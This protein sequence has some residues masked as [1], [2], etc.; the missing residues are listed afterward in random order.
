M[1]TNNTEVE[2]FANIVN[3]DDDAYQDKLK[4]YMLS[5]K[6]ISKAQV[7]E[8]ESRTQAAKVAAAWRAVYIARDEHKVGKSFSKFLEG[9]FGA[10]LGAISRLLTLANAF[11][12]FVRAGNFISEDEYDGSLPV[13]AL[14]VAGRIA[15][16]CRVE[17]GKS[18]GEFDIESPHIKSAGQTLKL[19][20]CQKAGQTTELLRE[21]LKSAKGETVKDEALK[22][23]AS[24]LAVIADLAKAGRS[25]EI[26]VTVCDTLAKVSPTAG[27]W[28]DITTAIERLSSSWAARTD[29]PAPAAQAETEKVVVLGEDRPAAEVEQPTELEL[30]PAT[31]S[32]DISSSD[33]AAVIQ[34]ITE[35]SANTPR[36]PRKGPRLEKA[37]D[38]GV[39]YFKELKQLPESL[40]EVR[41]WLK[42]RIS[43]EPATASA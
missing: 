2:Q 19:R 18:G 36:A 15:N 8:S 17:S 24:T 22:N 33:R 27:E 9:K 34:R 16:K 6:A 20:P 13:D 39:A 30:E 37:I 32:P 23:E 14:E 43:E 5:V 3:L 41:T 35:L 40:L 10:K 26:I 25:A 28:T 21:I 42:H 11:D 12:C 31:E 29:N 7:K 4:P 38:Q 1:S